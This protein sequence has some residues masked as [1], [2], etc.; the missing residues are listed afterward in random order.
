[1][2]VNN[3][4]YTEHHDCPSPWHLLQILPKFESMKFLRNLLAPFLSSETAMMTF[5]IPRGLRA[6]KVIYTDGIQ[7]LPEY[8]ETSELDS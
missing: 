7:G 3:I 6:H 5:A 2:S 8:L 4:N 1:M